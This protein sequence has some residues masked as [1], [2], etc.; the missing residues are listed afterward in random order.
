M[1][2]PHCRQLTCE[3]ISIGDEMTTG[4]RLDTNAQWLSQ[5]VG[6]LGVTVKFHSTVGD[7][8]ADNVDVFRIAAARADIVV[9]TGGLGP[10]RDDLTREAL[11]AVVDRP[12]EMRESAMKHIESMFARRQ[13]PMPE[14]NSV[15]AMFPVGSDE[16]FNP[17][18]TA[19]GIDLAVDRTGKPASR[20]FALPGVPAEMKRM[21]DETVAPRIAAMSGGGS[22][23]RHA[24]MKF[25]GTG[26]SDMEQRLGEMIS[27]DREPRVGITVSGATISL[28][29]TATADTD[30]TC[31][32]MIA[33]T[34]QE[35]LRLVPEFYFG[36]GESFEQQHAIEAR[37]RARDESLA[38]IEL[39][40]A[41]VLG[42]WFAS[43]GDSPAYRGG[44]SLATRNDLVQ[45]FAASDF[46]DAVDQVRTKFGSSWVLLVDA[47]PALDVASDTPLPAAD[48]KILAIGPDGKK[49]PFE[50]T[51]GGHPD[52]LHARI[53]KSAMAWLR[54]LLN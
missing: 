20:I 23:I 45:M 41:A 53:G 50:L 31:D 30:E 7:T 47:Y 39:G 10:T 52:I 26:E 21:F 51:I 29:I 15:Q 37:L 46:S 17:Q 1:T 13:R 5:R 32:A 14:R 4:A 42:D 27:R 49:Q 28:R 6:E 24:V 12:L 44:L 3:V 25:F 48:V 54:E 19:P 22:R 43:L 33:Q 18:G 35:I 11:A 40:R 38:V 9:A 2:T 8:L 34:R 16:V 36:D